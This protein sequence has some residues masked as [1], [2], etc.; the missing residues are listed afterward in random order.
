MSVF[1]PDKD[2]AKLYLQLSWT[3]ITSNL[4]I[5]ARMSWSISEILKP[6]KELSVLYYQV[7]NSRRKLNLMLHS[8]SFLK[9]Y[10]TH[11]KS[12]KA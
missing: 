10:L 12:K 2:T 9:Q 4:N 11:F 8:C 6:F 1:I 3:K 5:S 7:K